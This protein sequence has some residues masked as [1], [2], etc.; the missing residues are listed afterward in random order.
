LVSG[1]KEI[2]WGQTTR[3]L[4]NAEGPAEVEDHIR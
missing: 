3:L 2:N 4:I 1:K